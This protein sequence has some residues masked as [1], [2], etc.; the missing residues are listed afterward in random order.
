MFPHLEDSPHKT[1]CP[2]QFKQNFTS[3]TPLSYLF[4]DLETIYDG[5]ISLQPNTDFLTLP[6][7]KSFPLFKEAM[8]SILTA[9]S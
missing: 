1:I 8:F 9:F 2:A 4:M 7:R 5:W 3:F 6:I